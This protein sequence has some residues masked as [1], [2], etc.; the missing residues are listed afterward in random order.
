[1]ILPLVG[2]DCIRDGSKYMPL[3][4]VA[5]E[6]IVAQAVPQAGN[7]IDELAG[8]AVALA[9]VHGLVGRNSVPHPDWMW[10]RCSSRPARR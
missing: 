7:H 9:V 1:M 10:S 4:H 2:Q 3:S 8:A 6:G 5:D